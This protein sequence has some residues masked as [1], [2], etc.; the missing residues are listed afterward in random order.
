MGSAKLRCT[1]CGLEVLLEPTFIEGR[2]ANELETLN[3]AFALFGWGCRVS[4]RQ[5]FCPLCL[6][7]AMAYHPDSTP[8]NPIPPAVKAEQ[9]GE[10]W[11]W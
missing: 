2:P 1:V 5:L 4:P 10:L 6:P 3:E 11:K 8:A 7:A 9:Q